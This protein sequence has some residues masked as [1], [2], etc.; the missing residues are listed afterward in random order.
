METYD[1]F[2]YLVGG[3]GGCFWGNRLGY[4]IMGANGTHCVWQVLSYADG[5]RLDYRSIETTPGMQDSGSLYR[6]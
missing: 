5:R 6:Q 1:G 3:D 2:G 4:A